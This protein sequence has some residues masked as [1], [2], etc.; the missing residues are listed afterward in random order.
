MNGAT[1]CPRK[2]RFVLSRLGHNIRPLP[3]LEILPEDTAVETGGVDRVRIGR[4]DGRAGSFKSWSRL[5]LHRL[6]PIPR[7]LQ[8]LRTAITPMILDRTVSMS[9]DPFDFSYETLNIRGNREV[10]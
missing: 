2:G 5:K 3:R 6:N 9:P 10:S 4:V 8:I 1:H 7:P